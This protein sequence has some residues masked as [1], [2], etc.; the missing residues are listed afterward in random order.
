M[1][2]RAAREAICRLGEQLVRRGF[3]S[4][5]AGN[6]SVR[7]P[8]GYLMTPTGAALDRLHR[9]DLSLVAIDGTHVSGNAP[10]KEAA[11][12]RAVYEARASA[13]AV[14]HTHSIHAV[15]VTLL[16]E[17]NQADAL[18]PLTPYYVMR[19]GHAPVIPYA[20]PGDPALAQTVGRAAAESRVVLLAHHGPVIA[21]TSLDD[22]AN[23]LAELEETARLYLLVR[24]GSYRTL[25][26]ASVAALRERYPNG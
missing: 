13:N 11:L 16:P 3:V 17:V 26:E 14:I 4:G 2:H 18:P 25:D 1:S 22:A 5:A 9:R 24:N 20:P 19:V 10:T 15:A 23:V 6:I 21:G 12:H 7:V 8:E